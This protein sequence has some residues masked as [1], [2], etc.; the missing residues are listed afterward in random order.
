MNPIRVIAVL[1]LAAAGGAATQAQPAAVPDPQIRAHVDAFAA[2]LTGGTADQFEAMA[3][4][5][6]S[7]ALL[8]G[9]SVA[10][11]RAMFDRVRSDFG[12]ITV[13]S[14]RVMD[15]VATLAA[16]GET[17]LSGRFE[18]TLEPASP[19]R[20]TAVGVEIGDDLSLIHI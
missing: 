10:D 7:P 5:H 2:V 8:A 4:Q 15:G 9:R 6:F 1:A 3:Q 14:I 19:F 16:R 12:S 11:R 18:L 17:K 13:T 20:I